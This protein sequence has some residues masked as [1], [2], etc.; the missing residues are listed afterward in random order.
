MHQ[1]LLTL[2]LLCA[3]LFAPSALAQTYVDVKSAVAIDQSRGVDRTLDYASLVAFGPWDDRNYQLKASDLAILGANEAAIREPLPVY[4]RIAIRRA[5]PE[6]SRDSAAHYPLYALNL[7]RQQAGGYLINGHHYFNLTR[8][9]GR[10]YIDLDHD[11][12]GEPAT[13]QQADFVS[14][15]VRV[16]GPTKASE[17]AIAIHPTDPNKLVAGS[18]GP[19]DQV[20]MHYSTNGGQSWTQTELPLGVTCCDPSVAWSANGQ[21]AYATALGYCAFFRCDLFFY[22]SGD[23]GQTWSNLETDTPNIPRRTV[24]QAADREFIHVDRYPGSPYKDRVYLAYHETNVLQFARSLDF[25]NSWRGLRFSS[26]T[27]ELGVGGDITTNR[28]GQIYYVWPAFNSRTI[29]LKKSS[30]GGVSF[31]PSSVVAATEAAY[32]FPIPSQEIREVS[33]YASADT[34][35]TNGSFA[36]SVYVAWSD[37]TAPVSSTAT[38][39]HSRV[40]VAYSRNGGSSWLVT[41]PHSTSDVTT[42]DRWHPFLAV[43]PDGT[44]HVVYYD[45]RHSVNRTGVDV[46]YS[47][48]TDG[49]QTWSTPSRVTTT[50]SPMIQDVFEFGDYNGLDIVMNSLIA[51]FTDNR[52]ESG[53]SLESVDIYASGIA[54]GGTAPGAGRIPGDRGVPGPPLTIAKNLNGIAL[55]LTWSAACGRADDYEIYEGVLGT[56][57]SKVA[58]VCSTGG[59]THATITPSPSQRFYLVVATAAGVEG[60]YGKLSSGVERTPDVG[61]CRPQQLGPCP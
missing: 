36:D 13:E 34:D 33:V 39:N 49:A 31:G 51:S 45:T 7:F 57:N 19:L 55:D 53:G 22:R 21:Y 6:L 20:R 29:R 48:S 32:S 11:V 37:T 41:T 58:I 14:G 15:N 38:A 47:Y 43:G 5:L 8:R 12:A 4:F 24:S 23:G 17:S 52:N 40:R 61:S 3:S 44:V 35:L 2:S 59:M 30:D 10:Y 16:T 60:S 50:T 27:A 46:Y 54:S 26:D 25:G 42:V 9:D 1:R 28:S 56:P 18:I